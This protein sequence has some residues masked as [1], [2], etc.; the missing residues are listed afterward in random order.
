MPTRY[1][2]ACVRELY[3]R[4]RFVLYFAVSCVAGGS[5]F[6]VHT[7]EQFRNLGRGGRRVF[8]ATATGQTTNAAERAPVYLPPYFSHV[9]VDARAAL[10]S[11]LFNDSG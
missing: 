8:A 6:R 2:S 9:N 11:F 10:I 7:I 3:M 4:V 1:P 5:N